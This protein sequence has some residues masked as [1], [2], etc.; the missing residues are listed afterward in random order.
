MSLMHHNTRRYDDRKLPDWLIFS[1]TDVR[2]LFMRLFWRIYLQ[3]HQRFS[4]ESPELQPSSGGEMIRINEE[5]AV[6]A[7][8]PAAHRAEEQPQSL[9]AEFESIK[10]GEHFEI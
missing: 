1:P 8:E 10:V 2:L 4:S 6:K 9:T 3:R 7:S 5:S